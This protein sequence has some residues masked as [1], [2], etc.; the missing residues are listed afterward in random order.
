MS[1]STFGAFLAGLASF[2][3]PCILPLVPS[4]LGYISGISLDEVSPHTSESSVRRTVLI[5]ALLFVLGF[6]L[7]F[8]LLG[9]TATALGRL[10]LRYQNVMSRIGGALVVLMGFFVLGILRPGVLYRE[11]HFFPRIHLRAR[12][13]MSFLTGLGF[14]AG[15]TPCIGPFLGSI[16]MLAASTSSIRTGITLLGVYALGLALPFLTAAFGYG[17]ILRRMQPYLPVIQ[18]LSG[19]VMIVMGGLLLMGWYEKLS[20]YLVNLLG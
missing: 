11:L 17:W 3:S 10:L 18:K 12:Y 15:W 7:I 4:Y 2:A 14:G 6:S 19:G 20:Q 9:A 16:L 8:I 13:P 1:V 5:H